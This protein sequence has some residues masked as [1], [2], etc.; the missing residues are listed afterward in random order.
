MTIAEYRNLCARIEE[1]CRADLAALDHIWYLFR[2][3]EAPPADEAPAE[4]SQPARRQGKKLSRSEAMKASWRR[5]RGRV[6][7]KGLKAKDF[8]KFLVKGPLG[9]G[10]NGPE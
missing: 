1:R 8:N 10:G 4:P 3:P 9:A 7:E 2:S 5:R 6:A